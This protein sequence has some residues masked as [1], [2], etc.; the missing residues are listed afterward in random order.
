MM[1]LHR[2]CT[3]AAR[4][5]TGLLEL[6]QGLYRCHTGAVQGLQELAQEQHKGCLSLHSG[7]LTIVD[8][9]TAHR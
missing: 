3:G 5:C 1:G 6:A 7:S 4:P 8:T 9:C 2:R